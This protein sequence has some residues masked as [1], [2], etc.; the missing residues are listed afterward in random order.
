MTTD[1]PTAAQSAETQVLG[2]ML[3][4]DLAVDDV[5]SVIGPEDYESPRNAEIHHAITSLVAAGRPHDTI[6]V[7]NWLESAGDL[8]RVGGHSYL[9]ELAASV[10]SPGSAGWYAGLIRE[11]ALKRAVRTEGLRLQ[12]LGEADGPALDALNDA[13]Q[14]LDEVAMRG[15]AEVSTSA[16][17]DEALASLDRKPGLPTRWPTLTDAVG[18]WYPGE[19]IVV[20]ARP[21]IGKTAIAIESALDCARRGKTAVLFSLEMSRDELLLR[22]FTNISGVDNSRVRHRTLRPEDRERLREAAEQV[23]R[24]PLV[25]DDRSALTIA[26]VRS[27]ARRWQ[28]RGEVGLVIV[29]YLA[30][31]RP[32]RDVARQDRRVQVDS[33]AGGLKNLAK[34]LHVP[35]MALAQL[36]RGIE[37][38]TDKR[39]ILSDLRESGGIEAEADLALLM[40]RA[41]DEHEGDPTE[42][43]MLVRKNRHGPEVDIKLNFVGHRSRITDPTDQNISG[44]TAQVY[45]FPR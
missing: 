31:L 11:S 5:T 29:D 33:L 8:K 44:P 35:V 27:T 28:M 3:V 6:A 34:D 12:T 22:M 40:H 24:L 13:R 37:S 39:P 26:Q 25:I 41:R 10:V 17:V 16:A 38:R 23:K 14:R 9:H 30:K 20:A 18:G 4:D 43:E 2:A 36:N 32:G 1:G 21:G 42:L 45:P 19:F 15:V 7:G